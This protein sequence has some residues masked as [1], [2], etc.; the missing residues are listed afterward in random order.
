[1]ELLFILLAHFVEDCVRVPIWSL[2]E[3]RSESRAGVL[4]IDVD[5]VCQHG[6]MSDVASCEIESPLDG[7][8]QAEF[9]V[10]RQEFGKD[11]LLA[12]VLRANDD[13]VGVRGSAT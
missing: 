10:L 12:E 9:N 1:M 2:L 11:Y 8:M 13:A 4:G 7:D 3:Y 6:L 5:A